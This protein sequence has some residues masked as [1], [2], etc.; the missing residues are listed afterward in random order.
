MQ[1][2]EPSTLP[3]AGAVKTESGSTWTPDYYTKMQPG[4]A[5]IYTTKEERQAGGAASS[6]DDA[7]AAEPPAPAKEP[8]VDD[9]FEEFF[10]ERPAVDASL[11][12]KA[13]KSRKEL[14]T[15]T[16]DEDPELPKVLNLEKS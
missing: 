14:R 12:R 13:G 15:D 2:S 1:P 16:S 8:T 7:P 5:L 6:T 10:A 9:P 11:L 3:A 4:D